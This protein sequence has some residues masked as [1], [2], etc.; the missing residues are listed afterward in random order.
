[1]RF[2]LVSIRTFCTKYQTRFSTFV[3]TESVLQNMKNNPQYLKMKCKKNAKYQK[4]V[5]CRNNYKNDCISFT[6]ALQIRYDKLKKHT[7]TELKIFSSIKHVYIKHSGKKNVFLQC[8]QPF[9]A[10]MYLSTV[11]IHTTLAVYTDFCE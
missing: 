7:I 11:R 2:N 4:K 8:K 6:Y 5:N 1:M 3:T 10:V 9:R